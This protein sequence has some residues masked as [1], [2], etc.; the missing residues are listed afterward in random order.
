MAKLYFDGIV[1]MYDVVENVVAAFAAM[2]AAGSNV[3]MKED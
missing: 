3:T 2:Q 1:I